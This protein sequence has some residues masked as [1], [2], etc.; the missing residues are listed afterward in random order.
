MTLLKQCSISSKHFYFM[1]HGETDWNLRH[2]YMGQTDVPLNECGIKQAQQAAKLLKSIEFH[3]IATSPLIRATLTA[4]IVAEN[5]PTPITVIDDLKECGWGGQEGHPVGDGAFL[6]HWLK[7]KLYDGIESFYNF[8]VRVARGF[9]AALDLP[10]PVL[11]VAHGG[12]YWA[13]QDI[14]RLSI[15]DLP[16]CAIICHRPQEQPI[17]VQNF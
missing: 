7:G 9:K 5:I 14:L 6:K 1:R 13:I 4:Q 17:Q 10:G 2:I 3:S 16:N 11:I 15:Q 12:V 8:K